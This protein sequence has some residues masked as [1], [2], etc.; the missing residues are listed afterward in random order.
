MKKLT[1]EFKYGEIIAKEFLDYACKMAKCQ[2]ELIFIY[3]SENGVFIEYNN[4]DFG[5]YDIYTIPQEAL[6]N[7]VSSATFDKGI[8][9]IE[10][11]Y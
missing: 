9:K 3:Y 5:I 7:F 4:E 1:A 2:F 8:M 6:E 10:G 11:K